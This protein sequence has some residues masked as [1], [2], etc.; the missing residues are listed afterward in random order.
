MAW[1]ST[2]GGK[3]RSG[4]LSTVAVPGARV[5]LRSGTAFQAALVASVTLAVPQR[6]EAPTTTPASESV[7]KYGR[8]VS[9]QVQSAV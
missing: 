3:E 9:A 1:V 8:R 2:T 6:S 4:K 5:A 7:D